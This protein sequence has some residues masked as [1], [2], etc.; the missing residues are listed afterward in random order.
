MCEY[1][2][3]CG[4]E[5]DAAG[6]HAEANEKFKLAVKV[7][8]QPRF[9]ME[10]SLSNNKGLLYHCNMAASFRYLGYYETAIEHCQMAIAQNLMCDKVYGELGLIFLKMN[11]NRLAVEA[12]EKAKQLDPQNYEQFSQ[13]HIARTLAALTNP[14]SFRGAISSLILNLNKAPPGTLY[15]KT[16]SDISVFRPVLRELCNMEIKTIT[17]DDINSLP[18]DHQ[19][20]IEISN[21]SLS[22]PKLIYNYVHHVHNY[23]SFTFSRRFDPNPVGGDDGFFSSNNENFM[24]YCLNIAFLTLSNST[25]INPLKAN[26]VGFD[27]IPPPPEKHENV[28]TAFQIWAVT[29][30]GLLM[31]PV[32]FSVK[33][34]TREKENGIHT[35]MIVMGMKR[36][37]YYLSHFIFATIKMWIFLV[38]AGIAFIVFVKYGWWHFINLLIFAQVVIAWGMV[39]STLFVTGTYAM[40]F[41]FATFGF[42]LLLHYIAINPNAPIYVPGGAFAAALFDP[43]TAYYYVYSQVDLAFEYGLPLRMTNSWPYYLPCIVPIIFLIIQAI[44]YTCLAFYLDYVLPIDSSPKKHPLFI[45]GLGEKDESLENDDIE[46]IKNQSNRFQE[47]FE[48]E[49]GT[50]ADVDIKHLIKKWPNGELAVKDVSFKAYR[51]QVTALLGH[52]GAGKSTVF[53]CL[54]GFLTPT[55]GEIKIGNGIDRIGYCPQWDPLF[56]LLTVEEHLRFYGTLKTGSP[57]A[58]TEIDHV[59]QQIDLIHARN[60][61]GIELSGGMKRKLCVGM[62]MIGGSQVIL[63]DE[64]TAGMD[65]MARRGVLDIVEKIKMNKTILLTTH[66]MDEADLLSDRIIIMAKG[67][68]ICNG[69]SNFLKAKFGVGFVLTI[70]FFDSDSSASD[71]EKLATK[72]LDIAQRYCPGSRIEGVISTQFKIILPNGS[73]RR[74][75]EFFE[76]L[77]Q[78]RNELKINAFG[79]GINNLEQVFIKV[80]DFADPEAD[81]HTAEKVNELLEVRTHRSNGG[82]LFIQQVVA[83]VK[84]KL[85]YTKRHYI[86]SLMPLI[87]VLP[88]LGLCISAAVHKSSNGSSTQRTKMSLDID[89]FPKVRVPVITTSTDQLGKSIIDTLN[90]WGNMDVE[91]WNAG[92]N[93]FRQRLYDANIQLPPIGFSIFEDAGN[94]LVFFM[95]NVF[96]A[97]AALSVQAYTDAISTKPGLIQTTLI[98]E[99]GD[100]SNDDVNDYTNAITYILISLISALTFPVIFSPVI[101]LYIAERQQKTLHLYRLTKM[102]QLVYWFVAYLTDFIISII[103]ILMVVALIFGFQ[104]FSTACLPGYLVAVCA[105]SFALLSQAYFVTF[106]FGNANTALAVLTIYNIIVAF[107]L[108]GITDVIGKDIRGTYGVI[109]DALFPMKSLV[110]VILSMVMHCL[111]KKQIGLD[112]DNTYKIQPEKLFGTCSATEEDD[113]QDDDSQNGYCAGWAIYSSAI[114]GFVYIGLIV[115]MTMYR[116]LMMKLNTATVKYTSLNEDNDV[117]AERTKVEKTRYDDFAV[118]TLHLRKAYKTGLIAVQDLTLGIPKGECFGLLGANGAGKSTTFNMLT[119]LLKPSGGIGYVGKVRIDGQAKFGFCPQH[120][121]VLSDLTVL[122]T[123]SLF[124]NLNGLV[125]DKRCIELILDALQMSHRKGNLVKKCSGGEKRRLSIAVALITNCDVIMLDEPTAGVDP[126]TRRHVWDIL[127]AMRHVGTSQVLSSHS[128]EE[129]EALCT[130]IGFLNKGV[131]LGIGT[132]QHLK[133]RFGNS[134]MLTLTLFSENDQLAKMID[135]AVRQ[136][137]HAIPM[138][139]GFHA[140]NFSWTVPKS[141]GVQWSSLYHYLGNFVD[142]WKTPNGQPAIIDFAL[143]ESSLEQVFVALSR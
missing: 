33:E 74:F 99:K 24:Q 52:N 80:T 86:K 139:T 97:G 77:E 111:S 125:H 59:L 30:T 113:T 57:V 106:I 82:K 70:A 44:F 142:R 93:N 26:Q 141:P 38:P 47:F 137:F 96:S 51:G 63:L 22:I 140:T 12:F 72:I 43:F 104:I 116:G 132:S 25:K 123:M 124:A 55:A 114:F 75:A 10:K 65:P 95:R 110:Q 84:R 76:E 69:S 18:Y 15:V 21:F 73:Q 127:I 128:M 121:A 131:L 90:A 143:I 9:P 49:S 20:Y 39:A 11:K 138:A 102:S 136:E 2:E 94:S 50:T 35:Y 5:L 41:T 64:P 6:K 37:L 58:E 105:V 87:A 17:K 120:D 61:K 56:P 13:L 112:D 4:H 83:L 28:R 126:R 129:C 100:Y 98:L 62:A 79:I 31:I 67:E 118:S 119:G 23:E 108:Y 133:H 122:E 40:L 89:K 78:R 19:T 27:S 16:T 32:V 91:N 81:S 14:V 48:V 8:L 34:V 45:F 85:N 130:R 29:I 107:V 109:T 88:L 71:L 53:G 92:T 3:K 115:F 46:G 68:L 54:T 66:Y 60:F 117:A 7:I 135:E 134:F 36:Y 42:F 101:F 1:F 103:W